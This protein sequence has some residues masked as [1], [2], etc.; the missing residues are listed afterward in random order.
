MIL[1][2]SE[3]FTYPS[4]KEFQLLGEIM[5]EVQS[6]NAASRISHLPLAVAKLVPHEF[7]ACGIF[8]IRNCELNIGYSNYGQE[9]SH[10][11]ASQGFA[12]D[13]SIQLLQMTRFSV[14]SSED[15]PSLSIPR[16]VISLK[17]DFGIRSC[18]SIGVRGVWDT[19]TYFAFSNFDPRLAPKLR[20]TMEIMAPH[21]HLAYLRATMPTEVSENTTTAPTLTGREEEIMRWVAEGKTNWEISVILHVSLNTVKFHLKNIYQKLGG[22]ENRWCAVARWQAQSTGWLLA[23]AGGDRRRTLPHS[24]T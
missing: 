21:F 7:S 13:P 20:T 18:L 19:C 11:Y 9:F 23:D 24:S 6:L 1:N 5:H 17:L 3:Q 22:V 8:R 4:R 16:E 12:S 10:L 14:T 15:T 2:R